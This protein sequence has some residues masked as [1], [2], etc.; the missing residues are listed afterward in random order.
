ME[1]LLKKQRKKKFIV[2]GASHKNGLT[3]SAI[4]TVITMA[5]ALRCTDDTLFTGIW[6]MSMYYAVWVYNRI[7][8]MKSG[9]SDIKICSRSIFEPVS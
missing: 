1:E 2:A 8:D 7:P 9:L 3:E 6:P 4:N 5:S